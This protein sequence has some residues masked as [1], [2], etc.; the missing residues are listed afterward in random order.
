MQSLDT[1]RSRRAAG[2]PSGSGHNPA[3]WSGNTSESEPG[4]AARAAADVAAVR[5]DPVAR[6]ELG[7]SSYEDPG[8][9]SARHIPFRRAALSFMRWELDRGVLNA[10]DAQPPGSRWWRAMNERLLRDGQEAALRTRGFG[11]PHSAPT[12][13]FWDA[14]IASPTARNWYRAHNGSIA[15]AYLDHRDLAEAEG[16]TERFFLNVVLTRV[17][18][19]HAMVAAPRLALGHLRPLSR[20]L[21]DPR[22]GMAGIFLS[23]GRVLPDRYPADGEL[24]TYLRAEHGF[25]RVLDYAVIQPRLQRLYAWSAAELE[26]PELS[27][28]AVDGVPAYAWDPGERR[29]WEAPPL[30]LA[31]RAVRAATS[32]RQ[33]P[34]GSA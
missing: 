29:E 20:L 10:L 14:F 4:A 18:Y 9:R 30:P 17:L 8:G 33:S 21:G 26:R 31:A 28:L 7:A 22:L 6:V 11:G 16:R 27:S 23:L 5:D 34:A 32:V 24:D 2:R 13:A 25:G 15:A 12:V 1:P 3:I 19:A